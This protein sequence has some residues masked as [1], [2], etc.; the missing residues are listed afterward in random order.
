VALTQE[1]RQ[2]AKDRMRQRQGELAK[3]SF[4]KMG[5]IEIRTAKEPRDE[6]NLLRMFCPTYVNIVEEDPWVAT[7]VYRLPV[8]HIREEGKLVPVTVKGGRLKFYAPAFYG[9]P[10]PIKDLWLDAKRI[11][12]KEEM[13]LFAV[14]NS[15][16]GIFADVETPQGLEKGCRLL[17]FGAML[18]DELLDILAS[19][20]YED[21]T[22]PKTGHDIR[23]RKT[24]ENFTEVEYKATARPT[25]TPVP[26]EELLKLC[27]AGLV[28]PTGEELQKQADSLNPAALIIIETEETLL[29][30]LSTGIYDKDK[31]KERRIERDKALGN[32]AQKAYP[33]WFAAAETA[34]A[35][36]AAGA[37]QQQPSTPS[38]PAQPETPASKPRRRSAAAEPEK[39]KEQAL[40]DLIGLTGWFMDGEV[41]ATGVVK[42]VD[43]SG[44]EPVLV[45]ESNGELVDV[46]PE[47]MNFPTEE[48]PKQEAPKPGRARRSASA[49]A[50]TQESAPAGSESAGGSMSQEQRESYMD[51][52]KNMAG[53]KQQ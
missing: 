8:A 18:V 34:E 36:K 52:I 11:N 14:K 35:E 32:P 49:P 51:R 19:S 47:D 41:R 24:G 29:E 40:E 26:S 5:F 46:K 13:K 42:E 9:L 16:F 30:V 4:D 44:P 20:F 3:G 1:Q 48:A 27:P 15:F 23:V 10:D 53:N 45:V 12:N 33:K 6:G 2:A 50:Q 38:Q 25:P 43:R 7:Q 31:A 17:E 28:L 37:P 39:P 21:V 22:D